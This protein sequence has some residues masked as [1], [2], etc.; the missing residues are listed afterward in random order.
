VI[1]IP[2][3]IPAQEASNFSLDPPVDRCTVDAGRILAGLGRCSLHCGRAW[4]EE[5]EMAARYDLLPWRTG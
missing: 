3:K 4:T 5:N 2:L 1:E